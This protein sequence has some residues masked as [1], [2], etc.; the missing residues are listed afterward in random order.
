[1]TIRIKGS[2][3]FKGGF[4]ANAGPT[5]NWNTDIV[6]GYGNATYEGYA[7]TSGVGTLVKSEDV[8]A[9]YFTSLYFTLLMTH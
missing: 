9:Y 2:P 6:S 5:E 1:M 7:V 4:T 3:C 8:G